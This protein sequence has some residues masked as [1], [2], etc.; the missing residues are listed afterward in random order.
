MKKPIKDLE[1]LIHLKTAA[2]VAVWLGYSD[3]RPIYQ[4]LH[5]GVIPR[6]RQEAVKRLVEEHVERGPNEHHDN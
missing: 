3:T 6:A 4:W 1:R 5:R 2:Q